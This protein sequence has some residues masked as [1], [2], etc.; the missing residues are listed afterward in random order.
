MNKPVIM[1]VDDEA[2]ERETTG[3]ELQKRYRADYDIIC[4]LSPQAALQQLQT[5]KAAD[6]SVAILL[7]DVWMVEMPGIE[8]LEQAH[9][10]Y[11]QAKR[12]LLINWGDGSAINHI[13]QAANLGRIDL[14]AAKPIQ[15]PDERFHR[16]ISELLDEWT[17]G[18]QPP[19]AALQIVGERW[20]ARS[21]ELRDILERYSVG[22][23][24]YDLESEDGQA[25]LHKVNKPDGPFPIVILFNGI[26]LA[27]PPHTAIADA[28]GA[29]DRVEGGIYDLTI[30]GGGPAGL[31][32]AVYGASEGLRTLVVEREAIG[33]QAGTS[34][35][36]RNFLGFPTGISGGE[37]ANRAYT[38]AWLFGAQFYF[39]RQATDLRSEQDRYVLGLSDGKEFVSRSVVLAMGAAYQRLGVPGIDTLLGAGV[40]YGG[41]VT[42][43]MAMAGREVFVVGA[44]NS[45]GQAAIY[46]AKYALHV[47]IVARGAS[48]TASMSDYLIK[49]IEATPNITVRVQTQVVEVRGT[50]RLE[51]L[52]L[53]NSAS[54]ETESVKAAAIFILIGARPH[55]DWLPDGLLCDEK[56]YILTGQDLLSDGKLPEGWPLQ[57]APLPL[58]TSLPGVFAVGDVRYRSVKRVASGVG[59]GSVA[60]QLVHQYLS[61]SSNH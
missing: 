52:V 38:Q 28:L 39:M 27:D 44:G 45:A 33:G 21:H 46:L 40:F 13:V 30:V 47:T 49:E 61:E 17:H 20:S 7:A 10:L 23:R 50:R 16:Q 48:L 54:G 2:Q 57:R 41:A 3:R 35:R 37:L 6:V 56:H 59:E 5:F 42:E 8:F 11:P 12:L 31:S 53:K 32:A 51:G 29:N 19:V 55:T 14:F 26:V 9:D 4:E 36:I 24:F 15:L 25:L 22:F 34:S 58:E 43:A 1:L 60:I 18:R